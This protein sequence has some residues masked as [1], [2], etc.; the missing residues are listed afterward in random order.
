LRL[1]AIENARGEHL[2]YFEELA[3]RMGISV[4]YRRL[5][6]GDSLEGALSHDFIVILGGPM[7]VNDTA[8]YPYLR[9]EVELIRK[10]LSSGKKLLG[11]CLGAQL[12]AKALNSKV[13]PGDVKEIGWYPVELTEEA[14]EDE[15]FSRFP[16]SF[17][18]FQWHGETFDLPPGTVHIAQSQFYPN[19]A[20]RIGKSYALQFHFEV[21]A[22]MVK[23]WSREVPELRGEILSNLEEKIERLNKLAEL[24]F[25]KW[26]EI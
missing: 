21:T 4:S 23:D 9:E 20:F 7:S 8:E 15:I 18:V 22:E 1:L 12:M 14:R 24:F 19:Q 17:E 3:E 26:I 13:F 11:I 25:E 10:A 6:K 2:G 5:W 16:Q